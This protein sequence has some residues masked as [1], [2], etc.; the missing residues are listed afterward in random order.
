[1][2]RAAASSEISS[3]AVTRASL[4]PGA[5]RAYPRESIEAARA[6]ERSR[7]SASTGSAQVST[8]RTPRSSWPR[9]RRARRTRTTD[10]TS[11]G[12]TVTAITIAVPTWCSEAGK[13]R[14]AR[15]G[16]ASAL[17]A[18]KQ[19]ISAASRNPPYTAAS[20][21]VRCTG[22]SSSTPAAQPG[23]DTTGRSTSTGPPAL[24]PTST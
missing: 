19:M 20:S 22:P 17:A 5:D 1:M 7:E 13:Q 18:P 12:V 21:P 23:I 4:R 11:W 15:F 6:S 16:L 9:S 3:A 2:P 8:E 14:R 24:I 10:E